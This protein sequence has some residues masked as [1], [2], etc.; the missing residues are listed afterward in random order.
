MK[1][2]RV[3]GKPKIASYGNTGNK[4][5]LL[6]KLIFFYEDNGV[7]KSHIIPAGFIIDCPKKYS[8]AIKYC[9]FVKAYI[10]QNVN[11]K[12]PKETYRLC[13][14][15]SKIP[16]H[17]RLCVYVINRFFRKNTKIEETKK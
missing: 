9:E 6:D 3:T 12:E 8:N 7:F 4:Y 1:I 10:A 16:L 14:K 15:N 11:N 17:K 2:L 13:L 5:Q